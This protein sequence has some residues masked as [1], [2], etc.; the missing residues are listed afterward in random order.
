M[1]HPAIK[2]IKI[3]GDNV[4]FLF[5]KIRSVL[6][7][8]LWDVY[9]SG[10]EDDISNDVYDKIYTPIASMNLG[11]IQRQCLRDKVRRNK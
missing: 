3:D 5:W 1:I 6:N 4:D 7:N 2:T 8:I 10:E 9:N 11:F